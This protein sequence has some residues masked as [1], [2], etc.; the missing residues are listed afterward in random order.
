MRSV[1]LFVYQNKRLRDVATHAVA[2]ASIAIRL[3][4]KKKG[5]KIKENLIKSC[6]LFHSLRSQY[7]L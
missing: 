5:E 2:D 1:F 4:K 7:R 6:T 3:R